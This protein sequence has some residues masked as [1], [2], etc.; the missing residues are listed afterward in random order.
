MTKE[1][2]LIETIKE[3]F[4]TIIL[5]FIITFL[6]TRITVLTVISGNSMYPTFKDG[7]KFMV[8]KVAYSFNSP[9]QDDIIVFQPEVD[10]KVYFIKRVIATENDTIS[11]KDNKVYINDMEIKELYLNE[12]MNTNDYGKVKVPKGQVFVMGDNRNNS[13]DSRSL[14][15]IKTEN[16]LGKLIVL[17]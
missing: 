17:K 15:L 8:N 9:K 14:G 6:I 4:K 10:N 13:L 5:A 3:L 12:P 16:I 2:K 7:Q 1:N 11:I